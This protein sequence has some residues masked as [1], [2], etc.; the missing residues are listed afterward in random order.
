VTARF[1]FVHRPRVLAD[2]KV[3]EAVQF[4]LIW[5]G[6]FVLAVAVEIGSLYFVDLLR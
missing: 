6:V 1:A 4:A 5:A 2:P 3:H